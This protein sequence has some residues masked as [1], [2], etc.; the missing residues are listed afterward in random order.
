MFLAW[1]NPIYV[2]II[3]VLE[4]NSIERNRGINSSVTK[5][6]LFLDIRTDSR[7]LSE[8]VK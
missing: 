8:C 1:I 3:I 5:C 2:A 6:E 4:N 7:S